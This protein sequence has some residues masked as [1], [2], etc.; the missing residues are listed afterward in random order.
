MKQVIFP[1][2][3]YI[4]KVHSRCNLDCVYCYEYN[5][6]NDGWKDMPKVMS[7]DTFKTLCQRISQHAIANNLKDVFISF[8]GGEPSASP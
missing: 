3:F 6:G 4:V 1:I 7:I 5:Q 2:H 8:H